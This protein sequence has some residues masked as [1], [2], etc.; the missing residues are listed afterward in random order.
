MSEWRVSRS[1]ETGHGRH[2]HHGH[3][4]GAASH[5]DVLPPAESRPLAIV[6]WLLVGVVAVAPMLMGGRQASGRLAY[7]IL[8][9][10][11]AVVWCWLG[12]HSFGAI[13]RRLTTGK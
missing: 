11:A 4:H 3:R 2:R 6:D 8:F 1:G 5:S 13:T 7:L 9:G 10:L 12:R